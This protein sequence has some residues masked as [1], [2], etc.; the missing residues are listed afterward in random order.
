M[1]SA[2]VESEVEIQI[3]DDFA[4]DLDDHGMKLWI[5]RAFKELSCYQIREF[6]RD[7]HQNIR[8]TVAIKTSHLSSSDQAQLVGNAQDPYSLQS[9]IQ[10]MF[11]GEGSC[12]CLG[13]PRITYF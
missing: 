4:T 7:I 10:T 9:Y 11:A 12:R 6:D 2:F 8:A 13:I 5:H 3:W 1:R